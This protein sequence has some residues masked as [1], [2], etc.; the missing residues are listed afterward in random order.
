MSNVNSTEA[1]PSQNTEASNKFGII[2]NTIGNIFRKE[3]AESRAPASNEQKHDKNDENMAAEA[4]GAADSSVAD[5]AAGANKPPAEADGDVGAGGA[6]K[7]NSEASPDATG[8]TNANAS[9]KNKEQT[10]NGTA[11]TAA[12]SAST[13]DGANG[14]PASSAPL[15]P[16]MDL[17][18]F[19][20]TSS[21]GN[22]SG[23][24]SASG[25]LSLFSAYWQYFMADYNNNNTTDCGFVWKRGSSNVG[26][27]GTELM[28]LNLAGN[29]E[30]V[31]SVSAP[32]LVG[33]C[34]STSVISTS[35]NVAALAAELKS[36]YDLANASFPKSG[37][38]VAGD[39]T[40]SSNVFVARN[41]LYGTNVGGGGSKFLLEDATHPSRVGKLQI[42]GGPTKSSLFIAPGGVN[43]QS[44]PDSVWVAAWK[45]NN[46]V[47]TAMYNSNYCLGD[48]NSNCAFLSIRGLSTEI[49]SMN[50]DITIN[51]NGDVYLTSQNETKVNNGNYTDFVN[52]STLNNGKRIALWHGISEANDSLNYYGFGFTANSMDYTVP[53]IGRHAFYSATN[54]NARNELVRISLEGLLPAATAFAGSLGNNTGRWS[55]VY[56]HNGDF[57]GSVDINNITLGTTAVSIRDAAILSSDGLPRMYFYQSG[58]TVYSLGGNGSH[59]FRTAGG[60]VYISSNGTGLHG[61]TSMIN[62][63]ISQELTFPAVARTRRVVVYNTTNNDHEYYGLG[64]SASTLRY[65]VPN[66]GNHTFFSSQNSN[67]STE[68]VADLVGRVTALEQH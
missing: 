10:G 62:A 19:T 49:R 2:A 36:A 38:T 61:V 13:N 15:D 37:G 24:I 57:S 68:L 55:T 42:K 23:L 8:T 30:V 34:I 12:T 4:D 27:G 58:G 33:G 65:Q 35:S 64:I 48:F 41:V 5:N 47:N 18:R 59:E 6:G 39:A 67:S 20:D 1:R 16:L 21:A 50:G 25:P 26:S 52:S 31:G 66:N 11:A 51:A 56:G 14:T 28:T 44:N 46:G 3:D 45:G 17:V 22:R 54:S 7:V 63:T 32:A 53:E 43:G 29:L 60:Q 9:N 40:F